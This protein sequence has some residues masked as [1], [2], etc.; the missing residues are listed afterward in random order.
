MDEIASYEGA[1]RTAKQISLSVIAA[2]RVAGP[3]RGGKPNKLRPVDVMRQ[4]G[5]SRST[6]RPLLN[7]TGPEH[8]N[9]DLGTLQRLADVIGVPVAFL[10]MT[11]SD[12][13]VLNSAIDAIA[14]SRQAAREVVGDELG[15]PALAE[16]VLRRCKVHP[17]RPPLGVAPDPKE[18]ERLDARN[19]WRRRCSFVMAALTQPAGRGDQ[20][21][22]AELTALAASLAN[23]M[24]P[25]DPLAE[26]S[27]R[28][29]V[30]P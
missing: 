8:R 27:N 13:R 18:M 1:R 29:K 22:F 16:T 14:D 5:M 2:L 12:W 30:G 6:L 3:T 4:T 28:E 19:E 25:H 24:T 17:D 21:A 20:R 7:P 15:S 11:P 9:P 26:Q 10:L 23:A